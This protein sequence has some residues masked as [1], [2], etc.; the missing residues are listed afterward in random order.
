MLCVA[1]RRRADGLAYDVTF[2]PWLTLRPSIRM[3]DLLAPII[4]RTL[5]ADP[6]GQLFVFQLD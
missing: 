5:A 6:H 1:G 2:V 3:W 4:H